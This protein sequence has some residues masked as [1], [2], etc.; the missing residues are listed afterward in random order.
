ML[1]ERTRGWFARA[2]YERGTPCWPARAR[3]LIAK[4]ATAM[5]ERLRPFIAEPTIG[6]P[7]GNVA[8][9]D[10]LDIAQTCAWSRSGRQIRIRYR[11]QHTQ[12]SQRTIWPVIIGYAETVRLA[13]WREFR[14]DFRHFRTDRIVAAE[15][16][17]EYHGS[18]PGDLGTR[19]KRHMENER[20]V[21]LS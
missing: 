8:A 14:Q 2:Q 16:L 12:D 7:P 4:I 19:W 20:G 21:R 15:F 18:R 9:P 6:A 5:P 3:D 13:A 10:G 17:D 11:N 1:I